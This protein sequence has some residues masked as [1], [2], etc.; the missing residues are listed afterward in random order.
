MSYFS[1]LVIDRREYLVLATMLIFLHG[2]LWIDFGSPLSRAF[3]LIHLGL[4]LIWQPIHKQSQKFTWYNA[5]LFILLTL[6]FAYWANW[7][8]IFVWLILLIGIVGGRVFISRIERYVYFLVMIF[9]VSELL[10]ICVPSLFSIADYPST[11]KML[12]Y[13]IPVTVLLIIFFPRPKTSLSVY[14]VDV[15]YAITASMLAGLLALGSLAIMYRNGSDYFTSLIQTLLVIG[16]FLLLIS[17]LL[18]AQYGFRGLSQIWERSL[19][20]IGTPFEEWLSELS[21]LKEEKQSSVEFLESALNKLLTLPWMSGVEWG[22]SESSGTL[23]NK[24]RYK[25]NLEITGQPVTLYTRVPTGGALLL[26]CKLLIKLIEYFYESKLN[27]HKLAKQAHLQAIFE[28][29]AR[30]THD[31]KNLLQSMHSM[32]T[33]LQADTS[34]SDSK[35]VVILKKQ[36]PYFI[37]RLEQA[38]NK[39]QTPRQLEQNQQERDAIYINDWWRELKNHYKD[40][41]ISFRADITDNLQIPFD[42]FDSATENLL[43]NAISKRKNNPDIEI[44]VTLKTYK[45]NIILTIAD[46]GDA[47][48]KTIV[49]MLFREPVRSDNGL[50][51]GLLQTYKYAESMN[52][53]LCLKHN[54]TGNVCFELRKI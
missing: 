38:V 4:F 1:H 43:E 44:S 24:A 16:L 20:N 54:F 53:Q 49:G 36:F 37:Q 31:I 21:T 52:Y 46:S 34:E 2:A 14:S 19:L 41:N 17:W 5:I 29:G 50:G 3:I 9:L 42:L 8:L 40:Q 10:V 12:Q 28:T 32:V 6:A 22:L 11:Y 30:I 45:D 48:D 33:I 18:S 26:H 51:I 15:L 27:E 25:I 39:L 7:W 13:L 23:G 35:S 47:I